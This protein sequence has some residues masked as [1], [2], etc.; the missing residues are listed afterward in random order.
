MQDSFYTGLECG[1]PLN[2]EVVEAN[3]FNINNYLD[4]WTT[5]RPTNADYGH[6]FTMKVDA[7]ARLISGCQIKNKGKGDSTELPGYWVTREFRISGSMNENGP[8]ETLVEDE[9]VDT[10]N[11]PASLLNLT[12]K[13][14]VEI[15]FLRFDLVSFWG[16]QGGGLQYFAAIPATSKKPQSICTI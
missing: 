4:A 6:A 15:Q 7:C 11:K 9:L 2:P 3:V 16:E 5:A 1:G 12:F 13:E 8:W 14:P 10:R